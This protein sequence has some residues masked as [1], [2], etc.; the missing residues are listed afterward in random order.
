MHK[1]SEGMRRLGMAVGFVS[2]LAWIIF[3]A[4]DSNGFSGGQLRDWVI[5]LAGIPLSFG[6][7]FLMIWMIDW[8]I[9]GF[10]KDARH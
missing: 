9:A 4:I 3:V 6:F 10:R 1:P 7:C 2:T 8:V 5:F